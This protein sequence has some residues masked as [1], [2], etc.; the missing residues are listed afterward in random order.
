M[1]VDDPKIRGMFAREA[2]LESDWYRERLRMKQRRDVALWTR[3]VSAL[4]SAGRP[5]EEARAQLG[6]VTA[7]EYRMSWWGPSG[8]I[9]FTFRANSNSSFS[10]PER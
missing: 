10:P 2:M 6:R 5:V 7:P 9:R 8:P 3:H 1:G 4:E